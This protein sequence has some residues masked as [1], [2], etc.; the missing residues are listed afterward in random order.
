[1]AVG[2]GRVCG[3]NRRIGL[4][5][6][7]HTWY[8][9][10]QDLPP[11]VDP[12]GLEST[13]GYKPRR[14]SGTFSYAVHA[15]TVAVDPDLGDVELLDYVIV[16]D[17]GVLVNPMIVDGQIYGGLGQGNGT[18]LYQGKPFDRAEPPRATT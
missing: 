2:G 9:R 4:S 8:R 10:P 5:E 12:A 17:G 1:V 18:A 7:A 14:D 6:I 15:V 3:P 11:D 16:E 13:G